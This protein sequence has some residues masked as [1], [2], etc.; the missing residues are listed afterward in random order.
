MDVDERVRPH[1][2]Q[3]GAAR[4]TPR[5]TAR[6]KLRV[7]IPTDSEL[8]LTTVSADASIT[9]VLGV[10]RLNAVSGDVSTEI[11]G[12]DLELKTVSGDVRIKG[13][14]QPARLHV[15]TVSGDVHL[16]HGAGDLETSSVSGDL[17]PLPGFRALGA[18]AHHLRGPALRGQAQAGR[19]LRCG[20]RQR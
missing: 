18:R 15:S 12:A 5:A 4:A 9:G 11:A 8:H 19:L 6:R 10:Q 17:R 16:D 13:H 20:L 1:H 2:H 14:G 3:G 7:Q